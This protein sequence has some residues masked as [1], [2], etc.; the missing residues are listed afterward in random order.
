MASKR[1]AAPAR[2][3][4]KVARSPATPRASL[5]LQASAPQGHRLT[6]NQDCWTPMLDATLLAMLSAKG[7]AMDSFAVL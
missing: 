7:F 6:S 5:S 3:A 4:Q 2:R 1:G